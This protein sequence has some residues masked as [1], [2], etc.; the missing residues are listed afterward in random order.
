M[1]NKELDRIIQN[2]HK[3]L[4][5]VEASANI[6]ADNN[7]DQLT[8]EQSRILFGQASIEYGDPEGDYSSERKQQRREAYLTWVKELEDQNQAQGNRYNVSE[9][10]EHCK[11]L[12]REDKK[13]KLLKKWMDLNS[14]ERFLCAGYQHTEHNNPE[15][16]VDGC[17]EGCEYYKGYDRTIEDSEAEDYFNKNERREGLSYCNTLLGRIELYYLHNKSPYRTIIGYN[18][19]KQINDLTD[20]ITYFDVY[21]SPV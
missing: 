20:G 6:I 21:G 14:R 10:I 17:W 9:F 2:T 3:N 4:I 13:Q 1:N 12:Y 15:G 8:E 11:N 7:K 16:D 18:G 19:I 5:D